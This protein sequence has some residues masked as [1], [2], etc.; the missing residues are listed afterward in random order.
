MEIDFTVLAYVVCGQ[1]VTEE[2]IAQLKK[3]SAILL[4]SFA[5]QS[6]SSH[7]W[8]QVIIPDLRSTMKPQWLAQV[9]DYLGQIYW[10][11][12]IKQRLH[13]SNGF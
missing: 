11:Q 12:K 4:S 10:V 9:G 13:W 7:D 3:L 6:G 5:F 1:S 2:V 8:L